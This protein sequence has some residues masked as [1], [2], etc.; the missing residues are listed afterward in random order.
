MSYELCMKLMIAGYQIEAHRRTFN[1]PA[2]VTVYKLGTAGAMS[3]L[4][5]AEA[6]AVAAVIADAAKTAESES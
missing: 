5:P 3:W 2:H 4:T 6:R 1:D